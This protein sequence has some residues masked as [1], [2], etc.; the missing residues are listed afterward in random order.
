[1]QDRCLR[2]RTQACG[3]KSLGRPVLGS[4]LPLRGADADGK[5]GLYPARDFVISTSPHRPG[6]AIPQALWYFEDEVVALP[7]PGVAVAGFSQGMRAADDVAVWA[8]AHA[9]GGSGSADYPPL[10]WIAAPEVMH[11][12]RISADGATLH[13]D[14]V[15][16]PLRLVPKLALNRSWLDASSYA[17]LAQGTLTVR[18]AAIGGHFVARTL[19]PEHLRLDARATVRNVA[20]TPRAVRRLVR[21]Q[22]QGGAQAPF[23]SS[24]L[25]ERPPGNRDWGGKAILA[26]MLNGAQGDDD[27]AHGGHFAVV[28]GWAAENGAIGNWM[29]SNFYSLASYSEKGILAAPVPLDNYLADLN[30]GQAWYRP[31]Y[32]VVAI[33]AGERVP[34]FIHS[35]LGRVYNQFYRHQLEYDHASMNCAGISI[36]ALR[37]LGW[38]VPHA[39]PT[40][41]ALAAVGL[42]WFAIQERSIGKAVQTYD[43]LTEHRERLFP[44]AAFETIAA[45]LLA[46]ARGSLRRRANTLETMLAQDLEALVFLRIPQLP[47]SRAWGDAPAV[48]AWEYIARVP[49][50]PEQAQIIPLPPRPFPA[51]LRDADLLPSPRPRGERALEVWAALT[52]I[53]LPW[54]LWRWWRR[55]SAPSAKPR[56]TSV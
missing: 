17:F 32:L 15:S 30:S 51:R 11:G 23:A 53:G 8:G 20:A 21:E 49:S 27:E 52:V 19:W 54:A 16:S 40:S 25:W 18:G 1:V 31:S 45:D 6:T 14:G 44:G 35:A 50:D 56:E 12:A 24:V 38:R 47:S 22:A 34:V 41:R 43:Y 37:A 4:N 9:P 36:D 13:A 33:L 10:V 2:V 3:W 5:I 55:R 7:R 42:P 46:M 29:A 48:T 28:T 39:G 26:V